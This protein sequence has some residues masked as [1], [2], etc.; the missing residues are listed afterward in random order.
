MNVS[1]LEL[2]KKYK[3]YRELCEVLDEPIKGGKSKQLQLQ[4]WERYFKYTKEGNGFI[5]TEIYPET[6]KKVSNRGKSEGSRNNYEGIYN[7]YV[8]AL[9]ENFLYNQQNLHNKKIIYITNSCLSQE[10]KIIN[11]NYRI[12]NNNRLIFDKYL[13]ATKGNINSLA[14][15][16]IFFNI[17]RK[18]KPIIFRG[19]KKLQEQNKIK[20]K[21]TY[22][23]YYKDGKT[24]EM[25]KE[26]IKY[27]KQMEKE[28]MEDMGLDI[29]R[30]MYNMVKRMQYYSKVEKL[31]LMYL[32]EKDES[33]KGYY[34]GYQI[35]IKKVQEHKDKKQLENK[36]NNV[37]IKETKKYF[38]KEETEK[39]L[40][41]KFMKEHPKFIGQI[42]SISYNKYDQER[43]GSLIY[44]ITIQQCI[45]ILLSY[46][47]LNI[48]ETITNMIKT[49]NENRKLAKEYW[50]EE[51]EEDYQLF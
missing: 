49:E 43:L 48:T 41:K 42:L 7:K 25:N 37:V 47:T 14:T 29:N 27:T 31:V 9:I 18:L 22:I 20:Y 3:N 35:K 32:R 28:V 26:D 46:K 1:I 39:R 11:F 40:K 2:N 44:I 30:I 5:I 15:G 23:V 4:D 24:E 10:I 38:S 13:S 33:I 51:I 45:E 36:L 12:C 8:P 17:N 19:L 21:M 16:D 34:Q 50:N 6:K